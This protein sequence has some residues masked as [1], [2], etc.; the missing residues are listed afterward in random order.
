VGCVDLLH[1]LH[2]RGT[3]LGIA[4]SSGRALPYLDHWGVRA[5]FDA[6]VGREDVRHRKPHPE[7]VLRCVEK[8]GLEPADAAYV[9]DSPI[10]IEA[11][12]AAGVHTIGVLTGTSSREV[13]AAVG[14]DHLLES[15]VELL[16]LLPD[17]EEGQPGEG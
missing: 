12:R 7:V 8:L 10:D 3:R 5:V 9:G 1:A 2:A 16:D 4:T 15:A 6:I 14:P 11:G 17:R 13:L